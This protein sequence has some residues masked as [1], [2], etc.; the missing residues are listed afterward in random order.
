MKQKAEKSIGKQPNE[1]KHGSLK[2]LN[3]NTLL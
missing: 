3:K 2:K 1:I